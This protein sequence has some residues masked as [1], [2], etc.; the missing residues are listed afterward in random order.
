MN[1]RLIGYFR[2]SGGRDQEL[3]TTQQEQAAGKWCQEN[4]YILTRTFT[5]A[6]RPGSTT[7]RRDAFLEM[8][9]YLSG[10]VP[11]VGVLI[12]EYAR[13]SRDFDDLMYYVA[14][15]RRQG[16]AVHSIVDKIPEGLEGRLMEAILAW[17]NAKYLQD[18]RANVMRGRR[19]VISIHKSFP[20][21]TPPTGYRYTHIE[22]GQRRDGSP[23]MIP[24]LEPDPITAPLVTRAFTMRASGATCQEIHAALNLYTDYSSYSRMLKRLVYTGSIEIDGLHI[25]DFCPPLVDLETWQAAQAV[26]DARNKRTPGHA[27]RS[28]RS[29]FLLSGIARCA[30]CGRRMQARIDKRKSGQYDYYICQSLSEHKTCGARYIPKVELETLILSILQERILDPAVL[31]DL[32]AAAVE[33]HASQERD[34]QSTQ[35]RITRELTSTRSQITRIVNAISAAGHSAAL[36]TQLAN[37]EQRQSDLEGELARTQSQPVSS[38]PPDLETITQAARVALA[39][40]SIDQKRTILRGFITAVRVEKYEA[41]TGEIDITIPGTDGYTTLLF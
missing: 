1:N 3:S 21:G 33:R 4:G 11:E 32:H 14:D 16:Y 35:D 6:A 40:A 39:H 18:L 19:Y 30:R 24:R 26:N 7:N 20:G 8:I 34:S 13:L 37:L 17:K 38:A 9:R 27:P 41:I 23:H 36:I 2:D 10:D 31:H 15:L 12:W 5:D 28:V 25:D 29:R 22:I